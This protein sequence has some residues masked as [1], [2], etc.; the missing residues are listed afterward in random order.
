MQNQKNYKTHPSLPSLSHSIE[1]TTSRLHTPRTSSSERVNI[2]Q[3][4]N[5]EPMPVKRWDDSQ[6]ELELAEDDFMDKPKIRR[7][8][9]LRLKHF[10]GNCLKFRH[11]DK[12]SSKMVKKIYNWFT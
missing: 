6:L 11:Q 9:S 2:H 12:H 10:S 4:T 8:S 1:S 5:S 3:K 7:H